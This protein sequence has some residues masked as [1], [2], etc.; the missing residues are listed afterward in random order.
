M[1]GNSDFAK[2]VTS[3]GAGLGK[4]DKVRFDLKQV[5]QWDRQNQKSISKRKGGSSVG[6]HKFGKS[7]ANDSIESGDDTKYRDRALERRKELNKE[8]N[9]EFEEIV[10]KL[11]AE[12]TKFLGGDVEHTHLVKG[13]D[14]ALLQ[15]IRGEKHSDDKQPHDLNAATEK[16]DKTCRG[17]PGTVLARD[18]SVSTGLGASLRNIIFS[19]SNHAVSFNVDDIKRS[20]IDQND[21]SHQESHPHAPV[22]ATLKVPTGLKTKASLPFQLFGATGVRSRV[23]LK[24]PG[25]GTGTGVGNA[26]GNRSV[27][28]VRGVVGGAAACAASVVSTKAKELQ[29]QQHILSRT[30][31]E[32]DV[33]PESENDVP[34]IVAKS[35]K[36]S[37]EIECN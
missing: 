2:M 4:D 27:T 31:F 11:D 7:A 5:S 16:E 30:F 24:A 21:T 28:A 9:Q 32:F 22:R 25:T 26:F 14:Y 29:Q 12:Q 37:L 36:V 18:I 8:S 35:R 33:N 34:L 17:R 6:K 20:A 10:A 3:G 13:L 1:L 15:K 23:G 19:S